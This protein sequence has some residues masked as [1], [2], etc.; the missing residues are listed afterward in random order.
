MKPTQEHVDRYVVTARRAIERN[1]TDPSDPIVVALADHIA[2]LER[3]RAEALAL[4]RTSRGAQGWCAK[5]YRND[6]EPCVTPDDACYEHRR[7]ALVARLTAS[8][9]GKTEADR[10]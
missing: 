4:L 8:A 3:D 1:H 2:E 9:T 5:A 6:T 10:G 7:R